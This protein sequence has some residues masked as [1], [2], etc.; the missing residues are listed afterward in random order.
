M[1]LIIKELLKFSDHEEYDLVSQALEAMKVLVNGLN[2][3]KK[4]HDNVSVI[5]A[6]KNK[7][8]GAPYVCLYII[9][10]Y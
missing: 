2:D 1:K 8:E 5:L 10:D 4:E 7:I 9:R 6:L 3:K